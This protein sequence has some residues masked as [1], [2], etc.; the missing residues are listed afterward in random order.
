[1]DHHAMNDHD[2]NSGIRCPRCGGSRYRLLKT[3]SG[4][5]YKRRQFACRSS[6]ACIAV[7][8]LDRSGRVRSRGYRWSTLEFL[9]PSRGVIRVP[10]DTRII[11][12]AHGPKKHLM[13]RR[14]VPPTEHQRSPARLQPYLPPRISISI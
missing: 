12:A 1:M 3:R 11:R 9:S 10:P 4:R 6:E 7:E 14:H 5:G 13:P 2:T 8:N